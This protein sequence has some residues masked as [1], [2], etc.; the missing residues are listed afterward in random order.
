MLQAMPEILGRRRRGQMQ[1]G[2]GRSPDQALQQAG[3]REARG[4]GRQ[5]K[6]GRWPSQV[7]SRQQQ[8]G[9]WSRGC[10]V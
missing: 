3:R 7:G 10:Q 9:R 4:G 2:W 6:G 1:V 8:V 5:G